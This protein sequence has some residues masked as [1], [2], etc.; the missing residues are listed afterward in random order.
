M[1]KMNTL[2]KQE[3]EREVHSSESSISG[4]DEQSF[5]LTMLQKEFDNMC[6]EDGTSQNS[7]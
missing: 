3:K 4:K 2:K 5:D 7:F 1:R 6:N